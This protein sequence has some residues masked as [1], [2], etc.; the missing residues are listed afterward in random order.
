MP[1]ARGQ[2]KAREQKQ[3]A[4]PAAGSYF[5][6]IRQT[7]LLLRLRLCFRLIL[8]VVH[9][10]PFFHISLNRTDRSVL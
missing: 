9:K 2:K 3:N 8:R 1:Q 4:R 6:E 10:A 7:A 5:I